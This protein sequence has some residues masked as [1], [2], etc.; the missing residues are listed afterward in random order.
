M[1]IEWNGEIAER[2]AVGFVSKETWERAGPQ[3]RYIK[4]A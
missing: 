1:L 3:R 4:L 2:L